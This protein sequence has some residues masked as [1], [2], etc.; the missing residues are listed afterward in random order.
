M[1]K[2][3]PLKTLRTYYRWILLLAVCS[4]FIFY[5]VVVRHQTY[6]VSAMIQYTNA[7]AAAGLAPDGSKIDTSEIYSVPVMQQVFERMGLGYD[8]YNLDK[9]RSRVQVERVLTEEERA[10]QEA[11]N[12][13]GEEPEALSTKYLISFTVEHKDSAH[14]EAFARQVLDNMVDAYLRSYAEKHISGSL[15]ANDIS[16]LD[17]GN[18]DYL[19]M[20][21]RMDTSISNVLQR[22]TSRVQGNSEFRSAA[23]SRSFGDIYREFQQLSSIELPNLYAY[24]LN[25]QVAKEPEVLLAKYRNRI[26]NYKISNAAREEEIKS[27]DEILA[28]YVTLMRESGN[29][30]I[31]AEYI[32]DTVHDGYYRDSNEQWQRPD[33]T[34]EYDTLLK[35]YVADRTTIEHAD[36]DQDYCQYIVDLYSGKETA[37]PQV[38]V[39]PQQE[40][41][42][43]GPG[44]ESAGAAGPGEEA[45]GGDGSAE[46]VPVVA[47]VPVTQEEAVQ[48]TEQMVGSLVSRLDSLYRLLDAT[49]QEYNEYLGA[50]NVGLISGFVVTEGIQ[51]VLYS[52]IAAVVFAVLGS[53]AIIVLDRLVDLFEYNVYMNHKF[54]IP[55]QQGCDRY[56][57]RQGRRALTEPFTCLYF[58]IENIR[59]K[60]ET[61]GVEECDRMIREFLGRL[62]STFDISDENFLG[63]NRIGQ[64]VVFLKNFTADRSEGLLIQ[65][66]EQAEA[67]NKGDVCPMEYRLGIAESGEEKISSLRALLLEALKHVNGAKK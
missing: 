24:I 39:N 34:V 47:A 55:N 58:S 23:T 22:L 2:F 5:F 25:H 59:E 50:A 20:A 46:V 3:N 17:K 62:Q 13:Q 41:G 56:M 11:K 30:G 61:Y 35:T 44:A 9:F 33:V 48:V 63:M 26:E 37:E 67:Y 36:I 53:M 28:S 45:P 66:K 4:G 51:L 19:E 7:G 52:C 8:S 15:T 1:K 10:V 38:A 16:E 12:S 21:E 32:L 18:Y 31:T 60:N 54:Q 65:L 43:D 57:E 6:T 40:A 27:I 49:N 64:F 14:P 29:V 42:A